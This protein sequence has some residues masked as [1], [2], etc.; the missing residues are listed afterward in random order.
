MTADGSQQTE[1][2]AVRARLPVSCAGGYST[3]TPRRGVNRSLHRSRMF[4]VT[5]SL[6]AAVSWYS[7]CPAGSSA[8]DMATVLSE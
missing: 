5:L 3:D 2:L 7:V 1:G 4:R 8:S 6:S